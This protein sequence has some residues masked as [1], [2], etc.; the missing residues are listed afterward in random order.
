MGCMSMQNLESVALMVCEKRCLG[1]TDKQT[2]GEMDEHAYVD[3]SRRTDQ[4]CIYFIGSHMAPSTC[5]INFA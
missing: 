4:K 3:F 5:Y 1:M 2:D